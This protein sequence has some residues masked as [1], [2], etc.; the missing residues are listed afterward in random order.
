MQNVL[1][2][3]VKGIQH[4]GI[5]SGDLEAAAMFYTSLGFR[6]IFR[7]VIGDENQH[8]RFFALNGIVIEAYEAKDSEMKSRYN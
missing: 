4:I 7:T 6:E 1:E 2:N 5:P 8:V 3:I